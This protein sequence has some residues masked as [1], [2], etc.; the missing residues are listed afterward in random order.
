MFATVEGL[1]L[2][3]RSFP[4][5]LTDESAEVRIGDASAWL[6]L[7]Y[8]IP[9]DPTEPQKTILEMVTC[10]LVRRSF[11]DSADGSM[12]SQSETYGQFSYSK[13]YFDRG[14]DAMYLTSQE[15]DLLDS[16]FRSGRRAGSLK[17]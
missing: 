14:G 10:N 2:R 1:K 12:A 4:E 7:K 13:S 11:G 8:P 16:A 5:A 15:R 3:W 17:V 9:E 6:S